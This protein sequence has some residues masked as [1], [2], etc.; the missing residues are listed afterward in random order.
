MKNLKTLS[1]ACNEMF[2][3]QNCTF[4]FFRTLTASECKGFFTGFYESTMDGGSPIQKVEPWSVSHLGAFF[5][6]LTVNFYPRISSA[7]VY[8]SR[9]YVSTCVR[10][11]YKKQANGLKKWQCHTSVDFSW[12][13]L[14]P[15]RGSRLIYLIHF[16]TPDFP[17]QFF[18]IPFYCIF[19]NNG[20][21]WEPSD[22]GIPAAGRADFASFPVSCCGLSSSSHRCPSRLQLPCLQWCFR[23]RLRKCHVKHS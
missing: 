13:F 20:T 7:C 15:P 4:V 21:H 10:Y 1:P 9:R 18:S 8:A 6:C 3:F 22:D 14:S 19:R 23:Q 12:L 5:Q 16:S 17:P 2:I 11:V